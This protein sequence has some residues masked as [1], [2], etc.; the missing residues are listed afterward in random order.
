M[1]KKYFKKISPYRLLGFFF[2]IIIV[3][4]VNRTY[5]YIYD[6]IDGVGLKMPNHG[7]TYLVT[8][9]KMASSSLTYVALG[10][11]LTSG[12]G[13]DNYKESYPYL[14][15]KYF[16]EDKYEVIIKNRSV[17]GAKTSDLLVGLVSLGVKDNPDILTLLIGVNDI[18]GQVNASEFKKNY[19]EILRRLTSGTKAKIYIVNIPFIGADNL[20]L[21]PYNYYFDSKTKEFN[22]IVLELAN[23]YQ[24]KHIDLYTKTESLF[25]SQGAHYSADFF[26]PSSEGYKI[27]ADLIYADISN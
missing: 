27:W 22:E 6:H 21:P 25:K 17:P 26:H 8:N 2:L 7:V 15:A 4:Y 24:L 12:V 13:V 14:M 23:K 9:N 11:S 20:L 19:E 5:S 10:D 16:A 3:I 18:H 1:V